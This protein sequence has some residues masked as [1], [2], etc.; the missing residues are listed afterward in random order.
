MFH[1]WH[2]FATVLAALFLAV[3]AHA[4]TTSPVKLYALT[5]EHL[6]NPIGIGDA[7]PR[8][9]WKL[10]SKRQG[11]VQTAWEIRAAS[12]KDGLAV[13]SPDIWNSGKV[14]SNQSVL[15]PWGGKLLSSRAQVF[16]QV[17]IWD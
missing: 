14:N 8:L 12:S 10:E 13:A 11:E 1:R 2:K 7:S 16:W 6:T 3:S 17:R 15:V 4:E 5:C 9:S